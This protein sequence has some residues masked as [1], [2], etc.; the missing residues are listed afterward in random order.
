MMGGVKS[1]NRT[2]TVRK[3]LERIGRPAQCQFRREWLP[4][5]SAWKRLTPAVSRVSLTS[6][7]DSC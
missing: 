7:G 2:N 4:L 5:P 6:D 3:D 1:E